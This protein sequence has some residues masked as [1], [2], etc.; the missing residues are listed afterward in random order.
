MLH[1]AINCMKNVQI[2]KISLPLSC[3]TLF[4]TDNKALVPLPRVINHGVSELSC[5]GQCITQGRVTQQSQELKDVND[6]QKMVSFRLPFFVV[7]SSLACS[8]CL[9]IGTAP[10]L[11][12]RQGCCWM[13]TNSL[14]VRLLLPMGT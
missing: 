1:L 14:G 6:A 8:S 4:T 9:A 11:S 5:N 7:R 10:G 12:R 13:R 2:K 3:E